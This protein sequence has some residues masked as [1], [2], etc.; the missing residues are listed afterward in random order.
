M[1]VCE[2]CRFVIFGFLVIFCK[3]CCE[4]KKVLLPLQV[5]G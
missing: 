2:G 4:I 5:E 3:K 1:D